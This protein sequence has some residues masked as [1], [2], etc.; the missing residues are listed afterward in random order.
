LPRLTRR[1]LVDLGER[2][3]Q[4]EDGIELWPLEHFAAA[5]AGRSLWP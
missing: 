2:P 1:I 4:S 5:L 3:L